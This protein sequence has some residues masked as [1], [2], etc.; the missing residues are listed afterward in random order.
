MF[1]LK[2]NGGRKAFTLLESVAV[3]GIFGLGASIAWPSLR[4]CIAGTELRLA[5]GEVSSAFYEARMYALRHSANVAVLFE[6]GPYGISWSLYRD[7]DGDGVLKED[8]LRGTDK[9]VRGARRLEH[10]GSRIRFGF[11]PGPPPTEIGQPTQVIPN[12]DDGLRFGNSNMASFSSHGT[13]SPGTAYVTNGKNR[14]MAVRIGSLSG[15]VTLWDY[16]PGIRRWRRR[17]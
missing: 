3:L 15:K 11:P 13:A 9:P 17:G 14:L 4:D 1:R 5:A 2:T 16:D 10:F 12:L 7:G 6:E 8:I